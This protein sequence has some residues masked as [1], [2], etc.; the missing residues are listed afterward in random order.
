MCYQGMK[1]ICDLGS[2]MLT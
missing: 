1:L 2:Y